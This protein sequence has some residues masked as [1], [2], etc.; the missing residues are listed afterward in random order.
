MGINFDNSIGGI[1]SYPISKMSLGSD[2]VQK[3][4]G[5]ETETF[6]DLLKKVSDSPVPAAQQDSSLALD[7]KGALK[8]CQQMELQMN[9]SLLRILSDTQDENRFENSLMDDKMDIL[10][11]GANLESILSTIRQSPSKIDLPQIEMPEKSLEKI[12]ETTLP[13]VPEIDE[14]EAIIRQ[15]S[16]AYGVEPELIRGVV[17]AE[18]DFN[19]DAVSSKG[20][21]GL[22]QLMPETAKELGVTDPFDSAENIMGGTRYLKKLLDRYE[23]SVP[24]ALAAYNWGMG[25]MDSRRHEMPAE[26]K[27]Y[28]A[29]ITGI[30]LS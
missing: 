10:S 6:L 30:R 23:G 7:P 1:G 18:S 24:T 13:G 22:M 14:I 8:L 2:I 4:M 3:K 16:E 15:A 29:K 12:E 25:N 21:M 28:V 5:G 27:N 11:K 17:Q 19:P 26:T 9:Q 20:A